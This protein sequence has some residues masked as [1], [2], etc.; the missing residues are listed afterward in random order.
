MSKCVKMW[1][2]YIYIMWRNVTWLIQS[3]SFRIITLIV[4]KQFENWRTLNR[5]WNFLFDKYLRVKMWKDIWKNVL[6]RVSL[7]ELLPYLV[8]KQF[9]NWTILNRFWD[10]RFWDQ[11]VREYMEKC[12]IQG[13][14]FR[15][16]I[17]IMRKQFE[18]WRNL[19]GFWNFLHDKYS[20]VKMW[21][22]IWKN[23]LYRVSLFELPSW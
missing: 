1:E 6:Y 20:R 5:F 3:V 23:V 2:D 8:R 14:S 9:E 22:D 7:F 12:F 11:N 16:T 19:N 15:I 18:N 10:F 4:R 21:K 17:L 13:V